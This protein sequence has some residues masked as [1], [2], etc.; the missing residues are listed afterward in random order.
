MP[1]KKKTT[2]SERAYGRL[3]LLELSAERAAGWSVRAVAGDAR[4]FV[5]PSVSQEEE[6]ASVAAGVARAQIVSS[7]SDGARPNVGLRCGTCEIAAFAS[8][9]EQYAHFKSDWHCVNLK[10]KAKG[11]ASLSSEQATAYL[12]ERRS[13]S[14]KAGVGGDE[15][16]D[17]AGYS[18]STSSA[19]SSSSDSAGDT[20]TTS[21]PVVEF[22]DGT[23]VFKVCKTALD[24]RYRVSVIDEAAVTLFVSSQVYKTLMPGADTEAF[25]PYSALEQVRISTFRWA[26]FLLRSGR[27]AGAIFDKEKAV[28]HKTFQRYTTRR[29]QGGAQSASDASGKAKSA[30]AT[31]RRYNEAALK[32]DVAAVLVDWQRELESVELIFLSS[33]KTDRATF[34]PDKNAVLRPGTFNGAASRSVWAEVIGL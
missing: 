5:R 27:F 9:D 13:G 28:C 12:R 6:A 34:F 31:L 23:S 20:A 25:N 1:A 11:L 24:S 7:A 22:S 16:E 29:K 3:P 33:G 10:R 2:Q 18:S 30:G 32:Q 17:E 19:S 15:D 4:K 8:L 21:E 26:V 14:R